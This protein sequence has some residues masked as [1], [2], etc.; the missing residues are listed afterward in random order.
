MNE[1]LRSI[2]MPSA[3]S[4]YAGRVD[5]LYMFLVWLS[6][7]FFALIAG[8]L[9]YS[10]VKFRRRRAGEV[11]PNITHNTKLEIVW[12]VIP[13][14]L[15]VGIFFWA[16]QTYM[17][18]A[19]S[20][21]DA[22]E[23]KVTAK[24]WVW[25]FEYPNGVRTLNELHL[26]ANKPVKFVM[27]SEDVIHS[28]FLPT[29]RVKQDVLP[30]KYTQLWFEPQEAGVHQLFCTEY[31]GRGHSDMLAKVHVEDQKK[32]EEWL[33]T[34]GDAGKNMPLA[35]F[36]KMLY[37]SRGCETCHSLDGTRRDGPSF[38]G[39]FGHPVPLS[40]GATVTADE[41]YI[42]ES[43]LLPQSKLVAGFEGIMPTF[44]GVLREREIQALVEFIKEQK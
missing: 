36:G 32:Y 22:L 42:R 35:E 7:F 34:G 19:V 33:E 29:M 8:L 24:K 16:F 18:A 30:G 5:T 4:E 28:F 9:V 26:P 37:S 31:C 1:W 23:I 41:N 20:P 2:L 43:I 14:I 15:L 38:K 39:V 40:G 6:V 44:Q 3:G 12:S 13:T 11:T 25:E 21:A 10:V 27:I 17:D